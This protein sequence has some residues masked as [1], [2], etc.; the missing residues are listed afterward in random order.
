MPKRSG[1]GSAG[2][3]G[4]QSATILAQMPRMHSKNV[5]AR[6]LR[7]VA[8]VLGRVLHAPPPPSLR[9]RLGLGLRLG[10]R[11]R[12]HAP[13]LLS[14]D[15]QRLDEQLVDHLENREQGAQQHMGGG[16]ALGQAGRRRE[17]GRE[18]GV[19]EHGEV[20]AEAQEQRRR[21]RVDALDVEQRGADG[22]H[23]RG[24]AA[25]GDLELDGSAAAA[26]ATSG[27]RAAVG[28][29]ARQALPGVE[30]DGRRR[31]RRRATTRELA[32]PSG[33]D[34]WLHLWH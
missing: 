29:Q 12:L 3:G 34:A 15:R 8:W 6:H 10:L 2:V 27:A 33:C 9:L 7:G 26:N 31:A 20:D 21:V 19:D 28:A 24:R 1:R 32:A 25:A 11:L 30:E 17:P 14:A 4:G 22:V 13:G 23:D 16:P 5:P 18:P